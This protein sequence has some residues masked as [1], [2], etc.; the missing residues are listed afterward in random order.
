MTPSQLNI[1]ALISRYRLCS[2]RTIYHD[3]RLY[4]IQG[5]CSVNAVRSHVR[6]LEEEGWVKVMWFSRS[7]C[8]VYHCNQYA[9]TSE[10]SEKLRAEIRRNFFERL[11]SRS[12]D[13]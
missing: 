4:G 6:R 3:G 12:G 1:L 5:T 9:I 8:S 10:G 2:V 11:M 7:T 13:K